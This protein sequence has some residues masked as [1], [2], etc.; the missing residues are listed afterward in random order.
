VLVSGSGSNLQAM[1]DASHRQQMAGQ[2]VVV[3]SNK[4]GVRALERATTAG[5]E[6]LV[7]DHKKFS[8]RAA[9]DAALDAALTSRQIDY[10]LLAGFMRLLTPGF[11]SKWKGRLINI[12]PSLLPAFPGAHA[13]R[14]AVVARVQ[15]TGVTI[16]FVDEGTDTGP[17]IA[18]GTVG[19]VPGDT[20]ETLAERIHAVEHQLYPRAVDALVQGLVRLEGGQVV[21]AV[22]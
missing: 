8:D 18:Q 10:V 3:I 2:L 21:G 9:F 7:I 5:I 19:V 13:I 15:Q 6:P 17:I 1:I 11:V 16:H 20:K 22:E 4:P 12:H 14:D